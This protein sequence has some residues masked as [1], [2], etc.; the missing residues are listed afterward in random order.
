MKITSLSLAEVKLIEPQVFKDNRG[1]F[2]EIYTERSFQK[3]GIECQFVQ[4][5]HSLTCEANVV[6][7]LHFQSPPHAQSK[8][9][10]VTQ[11]RLWDVVVDIRKGSPTF[12]QH[13]GVEL[14]ARSFNMLFLPAGFAHGFATL[15]A[16]TEIQYKMDD[17]YAP[18]HDGGI[19]WNDPALAIDW[20]VDADTAILSEKDA[21]L[22]KLADLEPP[23]NYSMM[24]AAN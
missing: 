4:D 9:I 23:F 6:R 12:A 5:C 20:P 13:V 8:L 19:L 1:E 14:S 17:Y 22:P 24:Q 7:G 16:N 3:A 11:G 2:L 18:D 15:E 21:V 10:R